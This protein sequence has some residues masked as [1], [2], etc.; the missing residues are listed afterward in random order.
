LTAT[1]GAIESSDSRCCECGHGLIIPTRRGGGA[2]TRLRTGLRWGLGLVVAVALLGIPGGARGQDALGGTGSVP[3]VAVEPIDTRMFGTS[4]S[5]SH[6]VHAWEFDSLVSQATSWAD[7]G[8]GART[9]LGNVM[10][11]GLR[12]PRGHW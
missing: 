8:D 9:S 10:V 7:A 1:A 6:T 2:M 4:S 12:L 3:T 11:A 5:V